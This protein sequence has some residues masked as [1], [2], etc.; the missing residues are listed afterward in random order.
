MSIDLEYEFNNKGSDCQCENGIKCKNYKVCESILPDWW[1]E[2]KEKYLCTNCDILFGS[3][4]DKKGKGELKFNNNIE[5]PIC[6]ET[7]EGVTYPNCEHYICISCFKRNWYGNKNNENK[8]KFP[9]PELEDEYFEEEELYKRLCN[10]PL[11]IKYNEEYNKLE[12]G[13]EIA[14]D[15]EKYLRKCPFCRM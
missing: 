11:I 9:Y 6:Y 12:E 1:W 14:Y 13:N 5:C 3:W 2:C 10:D 8:P 4:G 15:N 7:N